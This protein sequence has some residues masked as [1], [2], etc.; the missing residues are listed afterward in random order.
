[1]SKYKNSK[2]LYIIT[3]VIAILFLYVGNKIATTNLTVLQGNEDVPFRATIQ[4]IISTEDNISFTAKI[5][6]GE[7]KG[8]IITAVQVVDEYMMGNEKQVAS[9]DKIMLFY[10]DMLDLEQD[11]VFLEYIRTDKL[12]ILGAIFFLLLLIFG[13][14]KGLNTILSLVLTCGAIFAMFI[15]SILS[16]HN[17][18]LSSIITCVYVITTTILIVNGYDKKSL[19]AI[20]GCFGGVMLAGLLT[21]IMDRILHLT[22]IVNS[23]SIYLTYLDLEKAIDLKAIIF[24]AIIVGAMGAIMDVAMSISSSLS[25]IHEKIDSSSFGILVKS[26]I[27]I[28]RDIMG[29]MANTLILAYIGSS[30]SLVL[31]LS[32][33]NNS[34]LELLNKEMIIV[35]MLQALVGS[36]G[37]LFTIPLTSIVS[38]Y[39]YSKNH[40]NLHTFDS[41]KDNI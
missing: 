31:I 17:I 35:E 23:E 28:G 25:E 19:S 16:G 10:N 26:G 18:Y 5:T 41:K 15:P 39:I 22:G 3:I 20:I 40:V 1:M 27:N 2:I 34:L 6:N 8:E 38:A 30:L 36:I 32:A 4:E 9:G 11:W 21:L 13:H 14:K 24:A 37:I 7:K 29:T 33:F 12:M